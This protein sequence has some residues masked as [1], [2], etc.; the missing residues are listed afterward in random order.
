LSERSV[1]LSG[2]AEQLWAAAKGG[3]DRAPRRVPPAARKAAEDLARLY[4][5]GSGK[6]VEEIYRQVTDAIYEAWKAERATHPMAGTPYESYS[7]SEFGGLLAR[8]ALHM[9]RLAPLERIVVVPTFEIDVVGG[10]LV[11]TGSID[12][13]PRL[14]P[15]SKKP[16]DFTLHEEKDLA[17][18]PSWSGED[19]AHTKTLAEVRQLLARRTKRCS[20]GCPGWAVFESGRGLEIQTCDECNSMQVPAVRLS[21]DEVAQLPEAQKALR[22]VSAEDLDD[23]DLSRNPFGYRVPTLEELASAWYFIEHEYTLKEGNIDGEQWAEG[24]A[25]GRSI[26]GLKKADPVEYRE[27]LAMAKDFKGQLSDDNWAMIAARADRL[28]V[29]QGEVPKFKQGVGRP[30]GVPNGRRTRSCR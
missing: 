28:R 3:R 23:N 12:D 26:D 24:L 2:M 21:D 8:A 7:P 29:D 18:K 27:L 22:E 15:K 30:P 25:F 1:I 10:E 5:D 14:N 13:N 9:G 19:I 17:G 16:Q 6:S 11:W 20:R 4:Q